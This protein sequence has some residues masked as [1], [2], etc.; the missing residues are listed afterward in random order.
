MNP[1]ELSEQIIIIGHPC[2]GSA[3][4]AEICTAFGCDV[5]YSRWEKD[6]IASLTLVVDGT[7]LRVENKYL[8]HH[9]RNP[10]QALPDIIE[11][12]Q[13]GDS[14]D[15]R[16]QILQRKYKINL[17][18][19]SPLNKAALS[20]IL[21]NNM[22]AEQKPGLVVRVED[23]AEPLK[24]YAR[25]CLGWN[26]KDVNLSKYGRRVSPQ[27]ESFDAWSSLRSDVRNF[28]DDWCSKYNYP[29]L[30]ESIT[31][32]TKVM[33]SILGPRNRKP[34]V[35]PVLESPGDD[36]NIRPRLVHNVVVPSQAT[37]EVTSRQRA[38]MGVFSVR[39][40]NT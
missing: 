38:R 36:I 22:I 30:S 29:K 2:C 7:S 11:E 20:F 12:D 14:Y 9:V 16:K 5:G 17:D 3:E 10:L 24:Q 23:A 18:N 25:N 35:I 27:L 8:I 37:A 28:L 13:N 40:I 39:S 19:Y 6:G 1:A 26:L 21:W 31:P 4:L 15:Y 34:T 33:T 32:P